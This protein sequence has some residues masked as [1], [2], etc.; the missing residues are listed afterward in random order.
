M[1]LFATLSASSL[2]RLLVFEL[3]QD[4]VCVPPSHKLWR[5][6]A[7][8]VCLKNNNKTE[9][10]YLQPSMQ[11]YSC[12]LWML[13]R[14]LRKERL[15]LQRLTG[16]HTPDV[17]HWPPSP[18]RQPGQALAGISDKSCRPRKAQMGN[19]IRKCCPCRLSFG[20]SCPV[21][22]SPAAAYQAVNQVAL[23][24]SVSLLGVFIHAEGNASSLPAIRRS[25]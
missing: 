12:C 1:Q 2:L 22:L 17:S 25:L 13:E 5:S 23:W 4:K 15:S 7:L 9:E 16:V 6:T 24:I 11:T 21:R 19:V 20:V 10:N 8:D 3:V 18:I 14:I